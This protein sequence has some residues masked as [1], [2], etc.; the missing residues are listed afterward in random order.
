[1]ADE[2]ESLE[3]LLNKATNP[4][5]REVDLEYVN[6]FC[7]QINKELEGPLISVRL[8]AH[9]I[10][11]PQ[12]R[13]ALYALATLETCVK[14][15]GRR[16]H[17]EIAKFRFLNEIIKVVSPKYLGNRTTEKVKKKCIEILYSWSRG[18]KHE[19]KIMEA[20]TMLKQQGIVKE[21]PTYIDQTI[22]IPAAT[23]RPKH[24]IYDDEEKCKTLQK[25]LNSKNPHD[26]QAANRLIKNMVKEDTERSDRVS[27]RIL[28]LQTINN[29][30]KLLNEMLSCY[31]SNT[32]SDSEKEMMK[33][34]YETLEKLRPNLFRLASDVD[35]KDSDGIT[36]I[37]KTNDEVMQVMA[38]YKN[39]VLSGSEQNG[40][41]ASKT[42]TSSDSSTLLDFINDQATP[43]R[44]PQTTT[45]TDILDEEL[46]ALGIQD[47]KSKSDTSKTDSLLSELDDL[48]GAAA[49]G[50]SN[51]QAQT[52]SV[53]SGT[54][55]SNPTFPA[56]GMT[57]GQPTFQP[58]PQLIRQPIPSNTPSNQPI[59]Q[60]FTAGSVF[61][62]QHQAPV[63]FLAN[64]NASGG[65]F[66]SPSQPVKQQT[67][68]PQQQ[69]AMADLDLL[70]QTLMQQSLPKEPVKPT[71]NQIASSSPVVSSAAPVSFTTTSST[72]G[73]NSVIKAPTQSAPVSKTEV[74]PLTDIFVPLET[75][76][77]GSESPVNAYDK[78]G[79][80]I[81]IH[82]AK[83]KPR[84][85]VMKVKL[86]PPS[87]TD[88]P[89]YNP[90]LPPAAITQVMLVANPHKEKIRLKFKLSYTLNDVNSS[91]LGEVDGFPVH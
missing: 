20:Y 86:Q 69:K 40:T 31:D 42:A 35:E 76:Q 6:A 66:S 33:E 41:T 80:K 19:P 18:L 32:S 84:E 25:L 88:L 63:G 68:T 65:V 12:E 61:N 60:G 29:N 9:K 47:N 89:A 64:N 50:Q 3:S 79:L 59:M 15:C 82:V 43:S 52:P 90:I 91:D 16:F 87:A 46:L 22:D 7:D 56:M 54:P 21:D 44:T 11:S 5:N 39:K 1:M 72:S 23:P 17:Q 75:I 13:E 4:A 78:N 34:F 8:I 53:S 62:Q 58:M 73:T 85:D 10:Q 49:G 77:P 57:G 38:L 2:A 83:D 55:L 14:K 27:K 26:L 37:L 51:T 70:G 24:E 30:I 74:L 48:F 28:E 45:G 71:L 81:V 36:E 67:V